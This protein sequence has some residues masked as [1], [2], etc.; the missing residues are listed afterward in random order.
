MRKYVLL[1]LMLSG[2]VHSNS[3]IP[4]PVAE[5]NKVTH[6]PQVQE[7]SKPIESD[8]ITTSGSFLVYTRESRMSDNPY[9]VNKTDINIDK[10]GN[11]YL[12]SADG[13]IQKIESYKFTNTKLI[14]SGGY[15]SSI[16]LVRINKDG[17]GIIIESLPLIP[18]G[19][20]YDPPFRERYS[21]FYYIVDNFKIVKKI[22][23]AP[24][25]DNAFID[26]NGNGIAYRIE[27]VIDK[28]SITNS[29]VH[30]NIISRKIVNYELSN[31]DNVEVFKG[32]G[33]IISNNKKGLEFS[34]IYDNV[35][36]PRIN[37]RV[38]DNTNVNTD[39]T[40]IQDFMNSLLLV[41]QTN[42]AIDL[43]GNKI[44]EEGN[45]VANFKSKYLI[46]IEDYKLKN[47]GIVLKNKEDSNIDATP[48]ALNKNGTGLVIFSERDMYTL[49]YS[50]Y[51]R[52]I[53][54]N[55]LNDKKFNSEVDDNKFKIEKNVGFSIK[56]SALS[57]NGDGIVIMSDKNA[58]YARYIRNYE[59]Q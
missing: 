59:L 22:E 51:F 33:V 53:I 30:R 37:M 54:N 58:I 20:E 52:K 12:I 4:S 11:G 10:N 50:S 46:S 1:T 47:T 41:G 16:P 6:Q 28:N 14:F 23:T 31:N 32:S 44:D 5:S 24:V 18:Q 35:L 55:K 15:L 42:L 19:T 13:F 38:V 17:K 2:C 34:T 48:L 49:E 43:Y 8:I 29:R 27:N 39:F 21:G 26:E 56:F 25:F 40:D 9:R 36:N 7:T 3:T 45:G 57:E